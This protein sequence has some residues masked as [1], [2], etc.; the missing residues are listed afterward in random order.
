MR[1]STASFFSSFEPVWVFLVSLK[2]FLVSLNNCKVQWDTVQYRYVFSST[3]LMDSTVYVVSVLFVF[4]F[5]CIKQISI[6]SFNCAI[7]SAAASSVHPVLASTPSL[8]LYIRPHPIH[9]SPASTPS[10]S[11]YIHPQPLQ[12]ASVST[13]NSSLYMMLKNCC[14][15]LLI[16]CNNVM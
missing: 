5:Y 7:I 14:F 1:F 3:L 16:L 15:F 4:I 10:L 13:F 8:S 6:S 2:F 11:L 12:P 9:P